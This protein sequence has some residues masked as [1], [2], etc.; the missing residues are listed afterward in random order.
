MLVL[1]NVKDSA[2]VV[3]SWCVPTRQHPWPAAAVHATIAQKQRPFSSPSAVLCTYRSNQEEEHTHCIYPDVR[4]G[5]TPLATPHWAAPRLRQCKY[6][7]WHEGMQTLQCP[8]I[9]QYVPRLCWLS[10]RSAM[11]EPG[12]PDWKGVLPVCEPADEEGVT[13]CAGRMTCSCMRASQ[14]VHMFHV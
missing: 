9:T 10:S 8:V 3:F 2:N 1:R 14:V 12:L 5:H 13:C 4:P 7:N 6:I 11:P